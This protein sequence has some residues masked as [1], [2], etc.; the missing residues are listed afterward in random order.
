MEKF[1]ADPVTKSGGFR[2]KKVQLTANRV[3][4]AGIHCGKKKSPESK[5]KKK[6]RKC[7]GRFLSIHF[8][9]FFFKQKFIGISINYK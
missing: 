8:V 1:P 4:F 7:P 3:E 5:K 9:T 2:K 6:P